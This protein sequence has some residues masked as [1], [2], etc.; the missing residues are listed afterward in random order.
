MQM[1][2]QSPQPQANP[3]QATNAALQQAQAPSPE[4]P[5][6][7]AGPEGPEQPQEQGG[8]QDNFDQEI[9]NNL[10]QH[11]NQL[12]PKQKDFLASSLQH[13]AN[14]V[15]PVLGIVCGQEVF[16]YFLN[17][18]KQNFA[19]GV[20]NAPQQ[21]NPMQA[22]PNSAPTP[23]PGQGP[24]AGVPAMPEQ[25]QQPPEQSPLPQQ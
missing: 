15:I 13:Y 22:Q 11:L 4:Q 10:E 7:E 20:G 2:P 12:N 16:D 8:G 3:A 9:L 23:Q 21:G 24:N 5:P 17:I 18:Y 19:K 6:M 1:Q 25:G 14:I